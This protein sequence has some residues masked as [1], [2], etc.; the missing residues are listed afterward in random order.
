MLR[1]LTAAALLPLA[2]LAGCASAP[3]WMAQPGTGRA[4]VTEFGALVSLTPVVLTPAE[5]KAALSGADVWASGGRSWLIAAAPQGNAL[6]VYDAGSGGLLKVIAPEGEQAFDQPH[7]VHVMDDLLLVAERDS[8]RIHLLQLPDF[9]PLLH[10][11]AGD[12]P[13]LR[14]PH[15]M[16]GVRMAD[17]GYHL[18]VTDNY[19]IEGSSQTQTALRHRVKQFALSK[20]ALGWTARAIRSF[21][22]ARG[23]G[24]LYAVDPIV[25]DAADRL[26]AIADTDPRDARRVRVYGVDGRYAGRS[27]GGGVFRSN[28]SGLALMTC[29]DDG[30]DGLWLATDGGPNGHY[31]HSFDRETLDYRATFAM[32]PLAAQGSLS[33]AGNRL[34]AA[35]E[36]GQVA[37]FDL[38]PLRA[39]RPGC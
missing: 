36:N 25:G 31:L 11:G 14:S 23:D 22:A 7:R 39:L 18:F 2:L 15:S 26:L 30:R 1:N 29:G 17:W 33:V 37:G 27:F 24:Q 21:G 6:H 34:Y 9:T 19:A 32:P 8:G 38:A 13:P 5:R 28:I 16:W 3:G 20:G 12:E 10:F 35:L 4:P